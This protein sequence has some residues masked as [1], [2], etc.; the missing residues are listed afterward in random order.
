MSNFETKQDSGKLLRK[1]VLKK[2]TTIFENF[3]R[4][5]IYLEWITH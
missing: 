5:K 3:V 1:E 4:L 2:L